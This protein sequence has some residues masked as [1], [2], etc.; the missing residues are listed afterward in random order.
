MR[1]RL[2]TSLPAL[3]LIAFAGAT[4]HAAESDVALAW[5]QPGYVTEVVHA[6]AP[7]PAI[8]PRAAT[9]ASNDAAT[10]AWQEPG[11]VEEVVVITANRGDVLQAAAEAWR[12]RLVAARRGPFMGFPQR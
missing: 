7:R 9:P 11:Y 4:A 5:Q 10:L 1:A 6:T 12:N 2:I 3:T 8:A